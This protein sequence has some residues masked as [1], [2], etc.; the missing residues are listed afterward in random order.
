MQ[1]HGGALHALEMLLCLVLGAAGSGQ[2]E[3]GAQEP[4]SSPHLE[5]RVLQQ[6]QGRCRLQLSCTVPGATAVSYSWSRG[7]EALSN[8]SMLVVPE[9]VQPGV[10]V[11]NV[12]NPASWSTASIDKATAC[13]Q[14]APTIP[15]PSEHTEASLTVYEEVGRA[16]TGQEPNRNSVVHAVGNTIYAMVHPKGQASCGAAAP[17][18]IPKGRSTLCFT[19]PLLQKEEVGPGSDFHCLH[20][21]NR[22]RAAGRPALHVSSRS[23]TLL[24]FLV[25]EFGAANASAVLTLTHFPAGDGTFETRLSPIAELIRISHGPPQLLTPA[26]TRIPPSSPGAH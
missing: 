6:E 21:G 25:L 12:S 8:Q 13:A 23:T 9:D 10:Y 26:G 16:Q 7:S 1:Q 24:S 2:G 14:K 15:A 11:C 20:G 4:V 17:S 19:V 22:H 18:S 3:E 5:M